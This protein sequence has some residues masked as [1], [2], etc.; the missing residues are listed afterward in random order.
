MEY[1]RSLFEKY[2]EDKELSEGLIDYIVNHP[3]KWLRNVFRY[4]T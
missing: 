2:L 4:Y 3:N 1:Y